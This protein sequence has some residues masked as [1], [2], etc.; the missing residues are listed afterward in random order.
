MFGTIRRSNFSPGGTEK[1][2][3]IC[4][5]NKLQDYFQWSLRD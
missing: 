3:N 4:F 2:R 1:T 5:S